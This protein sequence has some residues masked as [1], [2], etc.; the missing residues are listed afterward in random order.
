MV[1]LE[2]CSSKMPQ[3]ERPRQKERP[4]KTFSLKNY[5]WLCELLG[6]E[7]IVFPKGGRPKGRRP[8]ELRSNLA[9]YWIE[10]GFV[11]IS[12]VRELKEIDWKETEF[13][14]KLRQLGKILEIPY[15][16]I[17]KT[18]QA[19]LV[20]KLS[21]EEDQGVRKKWVFTKEELL[22]LTVGVHAYYFARRKYIGRKHYP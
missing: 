15:D 9:Q 4:P 10:G 3:V 7:K 17:R 16:D 5:P 20:G 11:F 13:Q 18:R 1:K 6:T 14:L 2:N 19:L 22:Q 21:K 12:R 8:R